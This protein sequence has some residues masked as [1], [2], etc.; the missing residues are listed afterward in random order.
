MLLA[1]ACTALIVACTLALPVVAAVVSWLY[2][3]FEPCKQ[4]LTKDTLPWLW[5]MAYQHLFLATSDSSTP[6][7]N[8]DLVIKAALGKLFASASLFPRLLIAASD[9]KA[10]A[11][12]S[13]GRPGDEATAKSIKKVAASAHY[14]A[15]LRALHPQRKHDSVSSAKVVLLL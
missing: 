15:H 2:V 12:K 7:A 11:I 1:S 10:A 6:L 4:L 9:L 5:L 13:L 3:S 14:L 8:A